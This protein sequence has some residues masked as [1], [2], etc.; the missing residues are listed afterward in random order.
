MPLHGFDMVGTSVAPVAI[1]DKC[2]VLRNGTLPERSNEELTEALEAPDY[3]WRHEK[4]FPELR[5]V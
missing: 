1:H 2:D 4:P 5:Q 3:G